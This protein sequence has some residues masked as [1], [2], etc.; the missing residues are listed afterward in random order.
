MHR[1]SF[2]EKEPYSQRPL[3]ETGD[4]RKN[5]YKPSQDVDFS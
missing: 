5:S 3:A 1:N 2:S 4:E